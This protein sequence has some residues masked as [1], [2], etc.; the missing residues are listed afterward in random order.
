VKFDTAVFQSNLGGVIKRGSSRGSRLK[1]RKPSHSI[2][3]ACN[4]PNAA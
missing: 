4:D 2:A 1:L 3:G